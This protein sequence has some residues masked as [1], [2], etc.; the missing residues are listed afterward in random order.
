MDSIGIPWNS[1]G[2]VRIHWNSWGSVKTSGDERVVNEEGEHIQ[3]KG[4]QERGVY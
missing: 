2:N 4:Q 3:C 1:D